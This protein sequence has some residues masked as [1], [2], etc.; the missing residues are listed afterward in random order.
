M[1]V[2]N[3]SEKLPVRRLLVDLSK[4]FDRHWEGGDAFRTAHFNALSMSFPIG[5][6]MFIDSLRNAV[7][8]L[9]QTPEHDGLRQTVKEFIGQEATHRRLH[10]LFNEHLAKQGLV[11]HI[12]KWAGSKA[13]MGKNVNPMHPLAATAAFEH[14]TS[15]IADVGLRYPDILEN[16][17]ESMQIFWRWHFSEEA[18]HKSVAMDVYRALG[19]NEYWRKRWFFSVWVVFTG[20]VLGQTINNLWHDKTL[21]KPSTWWSAWKFFFGFKG[22]VWRMLIPLLQYFKTGFHPIQHGDPSV[23]Q[24]WLKEHQDRFSLV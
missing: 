9:P 3:F 23:A 6:Q 10:G 19:G 13:A 2:N 7:V 5:E 24:N 16:A 8:L 22:M 15:V 1:T 14:F 4:G 20:H 18:E 12:E 11:N 21:F 17:S